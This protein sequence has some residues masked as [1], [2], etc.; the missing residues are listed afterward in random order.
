MAMLMRRPKTAR[1]RK[2]LKS[3]RM[4]WLRRSA[5]TSSSMQAYT[6]H[7]CLRLAPS[8]AAE[9]RDI[10]ASSNRSNLQQSTSFPRVTVSVTSILQRL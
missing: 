4:G 1:A 6:F 8:T 9:R 3:S 10:L 5:K 2:K 7:L